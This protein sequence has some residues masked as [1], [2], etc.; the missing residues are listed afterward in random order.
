M[1]T[2]KVT[3]YLASSLMAPEKALNKILADTDL[4]IVPL[5]NP[6]GE[7]TPVH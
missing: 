3:Q 7:N 6:D 2:S 5:V 4:Y 1:L